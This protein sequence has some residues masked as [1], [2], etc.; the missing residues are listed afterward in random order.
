MKVHDRSYNE[1]HDRIFQ[2]GITHEDAK[3]LLGL[4]YKE[5]WDRLQGTKKT[6]KE[7]E[8]VLEEVKISHG[9]SFAI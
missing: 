8:L 7:I 1:T 9:I 4:V 6:P 2:M 3:K 5:T